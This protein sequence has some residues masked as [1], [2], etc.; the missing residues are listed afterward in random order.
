MKELK[1]KKFFAI[2]ILFLIIGLAYWGYVSMYKGLMGGYIDGKNGLSLFYRLNGFSFFLPF[3]LLLAFLSNNIVCDS[4]YKNKYNKFQNNIITRVGYK[5]RFIYEIKS[6]LKTSFI[7][8]LIIHIALIIIIGVFIIPIGFVFTKDPSNYISAFFAFS[9]KTA[10]SFIFYII[11][12]CVGFSIMSLFLYSLIIL[13]KNFY[14]Y[15]ITGILTSIIGSM[16]PALLA[17]IF[18]A[19]SSNINIFQNIILNIFYCG[20]L[21]SPG[22]DPFTTSRTIVSHHVFFFVSCL[23]YLLLSGIILTIKWKKE[24][25][26]G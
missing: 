17:N 1:N 7:T 20:N 3:Y 25:K 14:L 23:G 12:S 21:L 18:L 15:K 6:V 10:I 13:I 24:K 16:V 26:Y 5:N 19:A 11:Y 22:I 9:N 8:R 4:F 2:I